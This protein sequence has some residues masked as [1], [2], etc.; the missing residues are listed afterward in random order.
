MV[1]MLGVA[2]SCHQELFFGVMAEDAAANQESQSCI[3]Q[4]LESLCPPGGSTGT[5]M[6][7]ADSL[8]RPNLHVVQ[9]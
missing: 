5:F 9:L 7:H 3:Y 1:L 6:L 2:S 4:M 8:N